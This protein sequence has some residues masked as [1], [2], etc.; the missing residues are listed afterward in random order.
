MGFLGSHAK[1]TATVTTKT[2]VKEL[3]YFVKKMPTA[4]PEHLEY[5]AKTRAFYKEI[6]LYKTLLQDLKDAQKSKMTKWCPE[7]YYSRG[8]EL[9]V[10]EDLSAEGYYMLPERTLMD[11]DHIKASLK[12][13]AAMHAGSFVFEEMF[14]R[15]EVGTRSPTFKTGRAEGRVTLGEIYSHLTFE[16]EASDQ[17]GHPGNTFYEVGIRGQLNIVDLL[18]GLS[19]PRRENIKAKLPDILRKMMQLVKVS[20]RYRNVF[21]HGDLWANNLL[22][23]KEENGEVTALLVDFQL[24][25]Y[26][27]P[28]HDIMLFLHLVQTDAFR[29]K[30]QRALLDFYYDRLS[31]ELSRNG[32]SAE[33][34]LPKKVFL[35]SC[36]DY[37][38]LGLFSSILYFHLILLPPEITA[39]WFSSPDLYMKN[40][41][42]DRSEMI[43][44]TF[45]KDE[46]F[47]TRMTEAMN[48]L[49]ERYQL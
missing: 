48:D 31:E 36:D 11:E 7:Y 35:Q 47:K 21:L 39:K 23:R 40:M 37:Y 30:H 9:V 26:A 25:R 3:H 45:T 29:R 19:Q 6:E 13:V 38:D 17:P 18:P 42:T 32:L 20:T 10:T 15:G 5:A 2:G 28:A 41:L 43:V 24:A 12:A 8:E 22:F 4:V 49:I 33:E 27:P 44:E 1:I 46:N 34:I 14:N 16:T